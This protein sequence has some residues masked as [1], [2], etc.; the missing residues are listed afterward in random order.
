M[1]DLPKG[2]THVFKRSGG[3]HLSVSEV[4]NEIR[5]V[6]KAVAEEVLV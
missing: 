3:R 4:E 2:R 5:K 6:Y 1:V